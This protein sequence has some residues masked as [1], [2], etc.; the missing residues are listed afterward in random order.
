[1]PVEVA[2]LRQGPRVAAEGDGSKDF[3]AL[4]DR[5]KKEAGRTRTGTIPIRV[6]FPEFGP[7]I[8]LA[9]ELTA[10]MRPPSL[11]LKYRRDSD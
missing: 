5:F 6:E 7:S 1:V 3:D 10:E 8:F 11:D 2:E 4:V 9:A